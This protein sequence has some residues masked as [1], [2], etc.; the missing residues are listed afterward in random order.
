MPWPS[1]LNPEAAMS[2]KVHTPTVTGAFPF[3]TVV[4]GVIIAYDVSGNDVLEPQQYMQNPAPENAEA[5]P[6]FFDEPNDDFREH[7]P[8][9][10][11]SSP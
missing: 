10:Y 1:H 8:L 2:T 7:H 11:G 3:F 6:Q 4:N 9:I 5:E